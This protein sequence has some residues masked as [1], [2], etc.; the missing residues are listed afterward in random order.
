[1]AIDLHP[2]DWAVIFGYFVLI[3]II[4]FVAARRVK[5]THDYFLGGRSFN[6][7]ILIAQSFGVGTHAEMPVSLTG[8]AFRSGYAAIWYQWKNLFITPFYWILAP[9]FRRCRCTT[10]GEFYENRYGHWMG[11]VYS[12]FALSYFIFNLGAMMKGA[13]KLVSAAAG[14]SIEPN[15][16]VFVM[17]FTFLIYSFVGGL[18]AAAYTDF[19]QSFF[20]IGLSFMLVPL[21]LAE[22]GGFTAIRQTLPEQML[23]MVAPGDIGVFM[24]VVLTINGLVGIMAQPHQLAAVGTGKDERTCRVGMAYGNFTKRFCTIGWALTGLIVVVMV[25]QR[26]ETLTDPELAFGFATRALLAP[27]FVGLMIACVLA[28]NMSTCSAMMVDGGA[29]FTQNLYRRYVRKDA[30]DR[31]YLMAGRYSGLAVTA[32]G[33]VFGFYVDSVLEAFLFTETIAAF[34]GISM[35]GAM[36]WKRANRWGAM[37]SLLAS[38][39][40]FFTMTQREFGELLRWDAWNCLIALVVGFTALIAVSLLTAREPASLTA[41]FYENLDTPSY[42]DEA[43]GEEKTLFEE[44]HELL[45]VKLGDLR[46]GEGLGRFYRRFRVD[47]VGLAVAFGVVI[48]LIALARGILLLP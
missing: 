7:W 4:G 16:V 47:L 21:G 10:I 44:G 34:M 39:L 30:T 15:T 29:L 20:I 46:L 12:V 27:G 35:F 24:I 32:L 38:S 22:I 37:A 40:V 17:T 11:G 23:S 9:I 48:A 41:P 33:I 26:G 43:S 19:A 14:G 18:Y 45:I 36:C 28:A 6:V 42:L 8:A 3:L 31:H 2:L 13:G 25:M 1:M 5:D